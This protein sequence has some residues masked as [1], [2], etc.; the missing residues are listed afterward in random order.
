MFLRLFEVSS[1]SC[2]LNVRQGNTQ[3]RSLFNSVHSQVQNPPS[4]LLCSLLIK[5]DIVQGWGDTRGQH[6]QLKPVDNVKN[7]H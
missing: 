1:N 4:A 5:T 2:V 3:A 7:V 6:P